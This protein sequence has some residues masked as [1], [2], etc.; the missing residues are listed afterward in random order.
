MEQQY[1]LTVWNNSMC[2]QYGITVC[3]D[4]TGQQHVRQYGTKVWADSIG[5]RVLTV[6]NCHRSLEFSEYIRQWANTHKVSCKLTST[7]TRNMWPL[8][9]FALNSLFSHSPSLKWGKSFKD[10][11]ISRKVKD[12]SVLLHWLH[13][14]QDF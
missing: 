13:F 9:Y 8:P 12:N 14:T 2:W 10:S 1:V 4:S 3:V 5:Q 6:I 7:L 11:S